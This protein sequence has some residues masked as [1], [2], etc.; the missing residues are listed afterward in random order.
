M[1]AKSATHIT[2]LVCLSQKGEL[3]RIEK[4]FFFSKLH[5]HANFMRKLEKQCLQNVR[6]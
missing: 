1:V 2:S 3:Y 5:V 4:D 6:D